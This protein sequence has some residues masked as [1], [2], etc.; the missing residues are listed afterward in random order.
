MIMASCSGCAKSTPASCGSAT[1]GTEVQM[2]KLRNGHAP[3]HVREAF[4]AAVES[5]I[6][7]GAGEPEP[8]VEYEEH[9]VP[10]QVPISKM[11]GLLWKC[12]DIIPG[13]DFKSLLDCDLDIKRQTYAACARAMLES[14]R[15]E[16]PAT[17]VI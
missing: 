1:S 4:L 10:R 15:R 8:T 11:C 14:M 3:G 7:W 13:L 12:T 2:P 16:P 17:K 9:Y 6:A 5:F